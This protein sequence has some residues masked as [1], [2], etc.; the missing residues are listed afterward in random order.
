[1]QRNARVASDRCSFGEART[2]SAL[3]NVHF[4]RIIL[5]RRDHVMRSKV[6]LGQLMVGLVTPI[7]AVLLLAVA[8]AVPASAS[9]PANATEG[10]VEP[11]ALDIPAPPTSPTPPPSSTWTGWSQQQ[12]QAFESTQW[13][14]AP[15]CTITS[16]SYLQVP[17]GAAISNV[18]PSAMMTIATIVGTCSAAATSSPSSS[19]ATPSSVPPTSVTS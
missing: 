12:R 16:V 19:F 6:R 5:T 7:F 15:G 3:A 18:P 11:V 13:T 17:V 8:A 1:M 9:T 4:S 2:L 14:A 10:M